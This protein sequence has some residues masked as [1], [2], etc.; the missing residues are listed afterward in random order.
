MNVSSRYRV[1]FE[2]KPVTDIGFRIFLLIAGET[3]G[4]KKFFARNIDV[5]K[6]EVLIEASNEKIR[7]FIDYV[8]VNKPNRVVIKNV[9]ISSYKGEIASI[10]SFYK[11]LT[12]EQL[13]KIVDIGLTLIGKQDLM[14]EKQDLMLKKQDET[15]REIKL[16]RSDL[17]SFLDERLRRIEEDIAK[18]KAKLGMA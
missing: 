6:V 12:L 8:S 9:N 5:N 14:L 13:S 10:D 17:K 7:E 15:L 11:I 2:G 3:F 1:I 16:L 18:I 4:F